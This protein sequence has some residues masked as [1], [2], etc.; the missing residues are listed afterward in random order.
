MRQTQTSDPST[1][2]G[3]EHS[4]RVAALLLGGGAALLMAGLLSGP[5]PGSE[6][7]RALQRIDELRFRYVLANV[8]DLAGAVVMVGGLLAL[9]RLQWLAGRGLLPV[10]GAASATA[11]GLLLALTLVYESS[12][13]PELAARYIEADADARGHHL[14]I[15]ELAF[16]LDAVVFGV[17]F[18]FT[19]GGIALLAAE[20]ARGIGVRVGRAL[21]LTGAVLA[22]GASATALLVPFGAPEGYAVVES[23]LGIIVLLWLV[24][25]AVSLWRNAG[26]HRTAAG[27]EGG[28]A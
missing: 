15:A 8:M 12:V 19:M 20:A 11:G 6:T 21:A 7:A 3:S 22:G 4:V 14:A 1:G 27:L 25:F 5:D 10:L 26:S 16:D 2:A 17:A 9:S 18:L 23:V 13:T 24:V 28:D